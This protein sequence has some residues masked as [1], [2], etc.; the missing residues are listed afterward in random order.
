MAISD[1]L[2][3]LSTD[4]TSAYSAI[5]TKGGTIPSHK[6]T[7]NLATAISSIPQSGGGG[8]DFDYDNWIAY[9]TS[10][11]SASNYKYWLPIATT[12]TNTPLKQVDTY[13]SRDS[14]SGDVAELFNSTNGVNGQ[15]YG[16]YSFYGVQYDGTYMY[17]TGSSDAYNTIPGSS[18]YI[19]VFKLTNVD[20]PMHYIRN[21]SNYYK[22]IKIKDVCTDSTLYKGGWC[23]YNKKIY[24]FYE[25]NKMRI[26]DVD[27][28]TT[29]TKNSSPISSTI[30]ACGCV[31]ISSTQIIMVGY[32]TSSAT[33]AKVYSITPSTGSYTTKISSW[34]SSFGLGYYKVRG[35]YNGNVLI[36]F[37]ESFYSSYPL[38][39]YKVSANSLASITTSEGNNGRYILV[40]FPQASKIWFIKWDTRAY[41]E[42]NSSGSLVSVN[43][44][45]YGNLFRGVLAC[46]G[47]TACV[48]STNAAMTTF[49]AYVPKMTNNLS[50]TFDG[51]CYY[52]YTD[53]DYDGFNISDSTTSSYSWSHEYKE[54]HNSTN[55]VIIP[56]RITTNYSTPYKLYKYFTKSDQNIFILVDYRTGACKFIY[57][58]Q[59]VTLYISVNGSWVSADNDNVI[60][61]SNY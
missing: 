54:N 57:N 19:Y 58:K 44:S 31:A 55:N 45:N 52:L 25:A 17:T 46:Q 9:G 32:T 35:Y 26:Y 51:V 23:V 61:F 16:R 60:Q 11:P 47:E 29:T 14:Y 6:N 8:E 20:N 12:P 22:R 30:S 48:V 5:N 37:S 36:T 7:D 38:L 42:V 21:T 13:F 27:N 18:T 43:L 39:I 10:T 40:Y 2:T 3:K 1:R 56:T 41:Y 50:M 15:S 53:E 49:T 59:E 33:S 24:L 34:T 4:I 28:A